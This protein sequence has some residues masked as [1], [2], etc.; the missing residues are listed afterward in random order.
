[1]NHLF[2]RPYVSTYCLPVSASFHIYLPFFC[3]AMTTDAAALGE[4][5]FYVATQPPLSMTKGGDGGAVG[6]ASACHENVFENYS[7]TSFRF[8]F[9]H[10]GLISVSIFIPSGLTI[11]L[12][13]LNFF[14]IPFGKQMLGIFFFLQKS[15]IF[16]FGM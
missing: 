7:V 3:I 10:E 1:M 6:A 16:A 13:S 8:F 4:L 2:K 15:T 11:S 12:N 5:L 9:A 14:F